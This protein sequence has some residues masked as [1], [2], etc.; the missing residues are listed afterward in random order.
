MSRPDPRPVFR[1]APSPN[2][3]LHLGHARSALLNAEMARAAGGRFLLRIEDIDAT[4][5]RPDYEAA[6]HEDLRWLGLDWERPV[7]R[8]SEHMD[9]YRAALERLEAM[10]LVYASFESRA[11][12]RRDVAARP[13]WP[14]DPDGAPL[15]P[16]NRAAMSDEERRTR[17]AAGEPY[18]LRLD[19]ARAVA[20]AGEGLSWR[21]LAPRPATPPSGG[22]DEDGA[23]PVTADPA[24]WGDVV[25]ARKETPTSYHLS[26]VVD[27]AAQ[28]V[29]H[30]V[31]GADL[32]AATSVH[33]LLQRLLGLPEPLYH[34]HPLVLDGEGRKLSK[35]IGSESLRD[36]RARGVSAEAVR[37]LALG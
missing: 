30:V 32:K 28:G 7:R 18:A 29:T 34:H 36:L 2:G 25:I 6:I 37:G 20:V 15:F 19:M 1:F 4:R 11:E 5:C 3:L 31:R 35:S 26:V 17:Q 14:V 33:R 9:A 12:I 22:R 23:A 8:Q 21:E 16:F 24:A 27:D 13:G 10:G